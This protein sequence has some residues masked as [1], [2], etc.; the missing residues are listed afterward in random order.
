[1]TSEG[2]EL[3][4]EDPAEERSNRITERLE[5]TMTGQSSLRDISPKLQWIAKIS[6]ERPEQVWTTLAH[7]IDVPFLREAYEKTRKDG[8]EGIDGQ[9]SA[10][11]ARNLEENLSNLEKGLKRGL[12]RAPAARRVHIPKGQKDKRSI[13]IP[14]FSDKVLQR[15]VV[16]VLEAVYEQDFMDCSYGFRP[17]RSAHQAL[18][19]VRRAV[20]GTYGGM[21]LAI[22]I[23]AFFDTIDHQH[24]RRFLD[25]RIRDGVLRR[26]IGKWLNAG[27]M[28]SGE[29]QRAKRGSPQGG[30]ISPMLAN[31]YLHE[32]LDVWFYREV[33]PRLRG[34]AELIRYADDAVIV[35]S[36]RDDAQRV[37]QVI[38]KRFGKYGLGLH[39]KKTKLVSFYSP[40]GGPHKSDQKDGLLRR[41]LP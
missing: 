35:I 41:K 1:M 32:V 40:G 34:S 33:K 15:A 30:V 5:G 7:H 21:V 6:K 4:P 3:T 11:F 26:V 19:A 29:I 2:G 16:M 17:R 38:P 18:E 36:R 25:K 20:M 22:D 24:L 12:Y 39:P 37:F 28:E 10:D 23:E 27:V 8:A 14:T 13:G 9:T 31:L